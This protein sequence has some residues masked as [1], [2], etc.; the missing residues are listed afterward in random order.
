MSMG[1]IP[2]SCPIS[3]PNPNPNPNPKFLGTDGRRLGLG[4]R[5]K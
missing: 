1:R 2:F 3:S 4:A 5:G